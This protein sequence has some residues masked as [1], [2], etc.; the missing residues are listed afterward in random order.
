MPCMGTAVR[1][2]FS[3]GLHQRQ[4][5]ICGAQI[6]WAGERS[7]TMP[8]EPALRMVGTPAPSRMPVSSLTW[9]TADRSDEMAC[10]QRGGQAQP[11]WANRLQQLT[12]ST[13]PCTKTMR[14]FT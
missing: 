13:D 7:R 8:V 12:V 10:A 9:D 3:R 4:Q 5:G 6:T 14:Q 2:R 1:S 11:P